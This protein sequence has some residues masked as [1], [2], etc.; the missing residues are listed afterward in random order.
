MN[1]LSIDRGISTS[2]ISCMKWH[3]TL[4][5]HNNRCR[6]TTLHATSGLHLHWLCSIVNKISSTTRIKRK[7]SSLCG[8]IVKRQCSCS[9]AIHWSI[10]QC[11]D[12]DGDRVH[13]QKALIPRAMF[14]TNHLLAKKAFVYPAL[15]GPHQG[16]SSH[17]DTQRQ[18]SLPRH[19]TPLCASNFQ[20][21]LS[22]SLLQAIKMSERL[23]M[24][25]L[26]LSV[27]IFRLHKYEIMMI[28]GWLHLPYHWNLSMW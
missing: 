7:I 26:T 22:C 12:E 18:Q 16:C 19:S 8:F 5:V 15:R 13:P 20:A 25:S 9:Q 1:L 21:W 3:C 28:S 23:S 24:I 11:S 2:I 6:S 14:S 27:R 10:E 17:N 4:M